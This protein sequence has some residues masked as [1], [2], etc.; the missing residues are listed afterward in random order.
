M[1]VKNELVGFNPAEF[2]L[3]LANIARAAP[4]R[5]GFLKMDKSGIWS[6]GAEENV[7]EADAEV[8]IDPRGFVHGWQCWA[9]T[10]IPG[11]QAELLGTLVSPMTQPVPAKPEDVPENGREWASLLG[12]SLLTDGHKLTYTTT[13]VGG[14]NAVAKLAEAIAIQYR[15]DKASF[16]PVVSLGTE[17]YKHKKYGKIYTPVFNITGW[18]DEL[19]EEAMAQPLAA[20]K[21]PKLPPVPPRKG[22]VKPPTKA[23]AKQPVMAARKRA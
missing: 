19:P 7:I 9:D 21:S 20:P 12:V 6:F 10:E 5:V 2:E 23:P 18:T 22:P 8:Y 11:V 1:N 15:K 4:A 16:I 17:S 13:S 3:G 14:L